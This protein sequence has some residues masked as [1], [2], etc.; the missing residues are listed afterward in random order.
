MKSLSPNT[1]GF[2]TLCAIALI[3]IIIGLT[4]L[5]HGASTTLAELERFR[6][7]YMDRDEL[8]EHRYERLSQI[9]DAID[10]ATD[11]REERAFLV[12]TAWEEAKLARFVDFDWPRCRLGEHGWCDGGKTWSLWQLHG[13]SRDY[14]RVKAASLAITSYRSHKVR[15]GSI[16]GAI[17]GYATGG[18]CVWGKAKQRAALMGRIGGRL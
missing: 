17:A 18:A 16:E 3:S 7:F 9:A 14:G 15:C 2:L 10:T 11:S 1:K 12:M 5:A 6:P 8:P 4:G 13:T